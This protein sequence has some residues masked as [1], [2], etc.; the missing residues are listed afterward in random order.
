MFGKEIIAPSVVYIAG[1]V[2]CI[3]GATSNIKAWGIALHWKTVGVFVY[4]A[5]LFVGTGYLLRKRMLS[6]NGK[7]QNEEFS[8]E[9]IECNPKNLILFIAFQ[10][11]AMVSWVGLIYYTT[12]NLGE[13]NSFSER[14]VAFRNWN[15][16]STA[17]LGSIEYNVLN[18][19][20]Q[21]SVNSVYLSMY[22]FVNNLMYSNG[23]LI[24][25]P[26]AIIIALSVVQQ[27]L[28]GGRLGIIGVAL[29]FVTYCFI[30]YQKMYK[31]PYVFS[32]KQFLAL[33]IVLSVGAFSFY[34]S[35]VIVGRGSDISL[36][37]FLPYITMY[38]GGPVQ[39]LDMFLQNPVPPSDI[40]GKET[41]YGLNFLLSR[42]GLVDF[43]PYIAHLEFRTAV[44][45]A[46]LGNIYTSYRSY[47]YDFGFLGLT[48]CPIIFSVCVH[49][50]Y[51]KAL[52]TTL[53][54]RINFWIVIYSLAVLTIFTDFVR[55]FFF[56]NFI[57][58]TPYKC[59]FITYVLSMLFLQKK[60]E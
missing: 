38:V 28:L 43:E 21:I 37:A 33:V 35:K 14:M 27:L 44:T 24:N 52:N 10:L 7:Q 5:L 8:S 54:Y 55:C 39:L 48:I 30:F 15:S 2:L 26:L 59:L 40:F 53:T 42:L 47:L 19:F 17:W 46:F 16:Y 31:K 13:F 3:L 41:L 29:A 4:G 6:K 32:V 60:K 57:S 9:L 18:Q 58:I 1:Y 20:V 50:M 22:I 34:L 51:Y 11:L 36:S 56:M 23:K 12:S 25:K 45:G 49:Y